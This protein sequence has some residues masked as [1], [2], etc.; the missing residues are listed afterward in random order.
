MSSFLFFPLSPPIY[1]FLHFFK[2]MAS[3]TNVIACVCVYAYVFLYK[4]CSVFMML[5][6]CLFPDLAIWYWLTNQSFLS[7]RRLFLPLTVFLG[8]YSS[9]GKVEALWCFPH[10]FWHFHW[11]CLCSAHIQAVVLV[12]PY[13]VDSSITRRHNLIANSLTFWL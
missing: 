7:W 5:P 8:C 4:A 10:L 11:C 12:S 3:F 1:P 9:L 6:V 2:F 13:G